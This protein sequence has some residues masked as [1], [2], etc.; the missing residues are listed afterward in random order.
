[1]R[2]K[3]A[4]SAL[5]CALCMG[6]SPGVFAQAVN[7]T[8]VG[9]IDQVTCTPTLAGG[10]QWN[11]STLTLPTVGLGELASAGATAKPIPLTFQLNGCQMP[12]S[13]MWVYFESAQV[14]GEG[15][16]IPTSGPTAT[17][18]RIRF[19]ILDGNTSTR[20]YASTT[21]SS[22]GNI[23]APNAN[24]GTG[25][26]FTGSG[27]SRTASK[28]YTFQYYTTQALESANAGTSVSANATYT[29]KYY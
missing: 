12:Q 7:F 6:A 19:E 23:G 8:I 2:F 10:S 28:T 14:D 22:I 9:T 5:S 27:A 25:V 11:G 17:R 18:N 20:V 13:N 4:L 16:I 29:V 1:M 15:R 24:Q 21:G 26:T 3:H